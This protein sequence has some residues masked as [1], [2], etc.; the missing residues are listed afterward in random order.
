MLTVLKR[1]ALPAR[2]REARPKRL[3]YEIFSVPAVL[4]THARQLTARL[5]APPLTVEE[6]VGARQRLLALASQ[7]RT[8]N[9]DGPA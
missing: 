4:R 2:L 9:R 8:A 3:R 7:W 6:L 1:H 5:G